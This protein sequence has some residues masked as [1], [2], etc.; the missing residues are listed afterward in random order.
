MP[1]AV[2]E[3]P[4]KLDPTRKRWTRSEY[5]QLYS[6]ARL[7][8]QRLELIEGEL[9]DKMGK[10]RPHGNSLRLL[11]Q[12][13]VGVFGWTVVSHEEPI[14]VAPEDNPTNEPEPDLSVTK[15]DLSSFR[16]N[17]RPEDLRL[18]VEVADSSLGLDLTTKAA[19]YARAGIVEYWVLDV[20]GR[21]LIV[22]RDP[23]AGRYRSVVAYGEHES[24]APL[25]A[26][27]SFLR[28]GDVFV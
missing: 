21:R 1:T 4:A 24:V 9:I 6:S 19:L 20:A 22:H 27:K 7:D 11:H 2:I 26:P 17:P 3:L 5:D 18:V 13:L 15:R 8:G 16:E 23:Q 14:D 25:G 12:W 10:N 28:V